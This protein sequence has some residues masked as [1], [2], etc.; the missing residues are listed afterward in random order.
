MGKSHPSPY[1]LQ[2]YAV[3]GAHGAALW[4]GCVGGGAALLGGGLWAV[5]GACRCPL[6]TGGCWYER[7]IPITLTEQQS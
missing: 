7:S 4:S 3:E 5:N 1:G 2:S 6:Y